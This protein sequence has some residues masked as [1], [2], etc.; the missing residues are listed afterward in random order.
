MLE[1]IQQ[2][3]SKAGLSNIETRV[4]NGEQ[5]DVPAGTFDATTCQFGLM[6]F[7]DPDSS[8]RSMRRALR[9]GGRAGMVV[10]TTPDKSPHVGVPAAITRDRL[11]LPPPKPSNPGHF[12]LG[13]PGILEKRMA[14]AA[15][16]DISTETVD[17][18]L[19]ADSAAEFI[20]L[21]RG[22]GAG[23]TP[24]MANADEATKDSIWAEITQALSTYEDGTGLNIPA[25]F[26]V[27]A[28][29]RHEAMTLDRENKA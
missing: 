6:L 13:K 19:R 11:N 2:K 3:A 14:S 27:A 25:E 5:L 1:I 15:F 8:L 28:G 16:A 17:C 4:M 9:P 7:N 12:S 23:P 22:A 20:R 26:L 18:R 10:F 24:M 21:F 29:S